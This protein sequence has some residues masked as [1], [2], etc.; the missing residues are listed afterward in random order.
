MSTAAPRIE[1]VPDGSGNLAVR[2]TFRETRKRLGH[3]VEP[4]RVLA[5][6]PALLAADVAMELAFERAHDVDERIKELA[7]LKV[8]TMVGCEFCIDIGSKTVRDAGIPEAQVRSL[9]AYGESDAFDERERTVLDLA[10][11]MTATPA[12]VS[13]EL[14]ARLRAH[15]DEPAL[16]ELVTMIGWENFRARTNHAFGLVSEGFSEGGVCALPE[17]AAVAAPA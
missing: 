1:G 8:A 16:V 4:V 6:R 5:R 9:A 13:D 12:H 15:F 2:A 14:W 11:G 10:A 7:V 17:R 3:V